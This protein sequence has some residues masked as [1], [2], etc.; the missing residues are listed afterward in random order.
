MKYFYL[1]SLLFHPILLPFIATLIFFKLEPFSVSSELQIKVIVL[2]GSITMLFPL[3]MLYVLKKA[4]MIQSFEVRNIKERRTPFIYMIALFLLLS[5]TFQKIQVLQL[6]ASL[7]LGCSLALI[8]SYL[9]FSVKI[10]TSIHMI[11][12][13]SVLSFFV[14]YG[15]LYQTNTI[16]AIAL[17]IL[18]TGIVGQSRLYLKAHTPFEIGLGVFVGLIMQLLAFNY[19]II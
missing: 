19:T 1:I 10:K 3:I 5:Y 18:I 15:L 9:L 7:F 11:G 8:V 16:H 17:S 14:M 6:L 4:G 2:V 12:T 13:V